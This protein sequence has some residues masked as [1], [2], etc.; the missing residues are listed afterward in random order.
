MNKRLITL[1][2]PLLVLSIFLACDTKQKSVSELKWVNPI[3]NGINKYGMKDFF[4]FYEDETFYLVGTE[5]ADPF[6]GYLGPNL[7]KSDNLSSWSTDF[8]LINTN[9]IPE[10]AWYKDGW[11]APEIVKIKNKYYFTFNNRNNAENPYQKLGFGIAVSDSLKGEY[12]IINKNAPIVL[13]NHGSLVV[14]ENEDEVFVV[15][16]MDSRFYIA[17]VDLEQGNLKSKPIEFLGPE[18]LQDNFKYLDAPQITKIGDTYH[19]MFSQFYGGY[20]VKI[21][22][23]TA[24]HPTETWHWDTNN[25]IYTFL[26][27]EADEVVKNK[28]PTPHGYAPPTQVVFSNQLFKG[29]FGQYFIAYHSS[30]KYSE[31]YLCVEPVSIENEKLLIPT[32]KDIQQKISLN[33]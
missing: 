15:Y 3:S 29:E 32:A 20:V 12:D 33:D 14:G 9:L 18:T 5:Y 21:Y 7:Y 26:E 30:E 28:Y 6:K 16:E 19:L 11:F 10:N 13:S 24:K 23:M 31:P 4:I 17:E 8:K 22:H 27:E 25:P 1:L 2:R